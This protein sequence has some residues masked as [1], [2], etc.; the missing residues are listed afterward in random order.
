MCRSTACP[1]LY[2]RIVGRTGN[3]HAD[4]PHSLGPLRSRLRRQHEKCAA[5]K[6]DE[7]APL[8]P[9]MGFLPGKP[10]RSELSR[11]LSAP[12]YSTKRITPPRGGK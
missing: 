7:L 3:Q 5:E 10:D 12:P 1:K 2:C 11:G 9:S 6:R 4:P 8:M